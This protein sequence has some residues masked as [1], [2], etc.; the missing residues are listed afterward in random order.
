M[1]PNIRN[2]IIYCA[3][4][5]ALGLWILA[6]AVA[7]NVPV[8]TAALPG[9]VTLGWNASASDTNPGDPY[10]YIVEWGAQSSN[11]VNSQNFGTNLTGMISGLTNGLTYYFVVVA[12]DTNTA[13][14]SAYS[15]QVSW[16][17]PV[18]PLAPKLN[19][20]QVNQQ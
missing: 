2:F 12:E 17:A 18:Q 10:N 14:V 15:G 5:A 11:Y 6:K 19:T 13:L 1:K 7:G 16:T 3:V 4:V 8:P 9:V 20:L